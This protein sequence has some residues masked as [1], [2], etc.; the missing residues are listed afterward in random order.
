MWWQ[1]CGPSTQSCT[2]AKTLR[3]LSITAVL[4]LLLRTLPWCALQDVQEPSKSKQQRTASSVLVI[5]QQGARFRTAERP[6]VWMQKMALKAIIAPTL[7]HRNQVA[8]TMPRFSIT[9]S[10]TCTRPV[11]TLCWLAKTTPQAWSPLVSP[12]AAVILSCAEQRIG[13]RAGRN[14]A[15]SV[16]AC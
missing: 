3:Q 10:P 9:A 16:Q 11:S 2:R 13:V 14:A 12:A 8:G 4:C 6:Q 7:I 1:S 15:H 5:Q